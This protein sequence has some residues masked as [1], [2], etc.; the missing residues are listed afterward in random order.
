MTD[1]TTDFKG[2]A[3]TDYE[4]L[5]AIVSK[6]E[7]GKYYIVTFWDMGEMIDAF[8]KH[9]TCWDTAVCWATGFTSGKEYKAV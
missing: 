9:T 4:G 8:T 6:P 2:N 3:G 1:I 7:G 5:T